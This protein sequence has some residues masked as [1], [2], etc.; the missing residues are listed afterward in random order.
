MKKIS[1]LS[2]IILI[3]QMSFGQTTINDNANISGNWTV[4]NSPYIIAGRAIVPNGQTLTIEPG[5]EIRLKSSTS[6]MPS[7]FNY[8]SGNVGVIRVQGEITANGTVSNPIIFTRNNSG[9][10]GTILIDENSSS[11]S[12][13]SHCIIE[14]AKESRNVTGISSIISFNGGIT[15]YKSFISINQN[16]F[17]NN[18]INGLYIRE[19]TNSFEFSNNTIYNNETNGVVIEESTANGIN[20]IFYNNSNSASGQVSAIRSS[21]S[22]VYLVGNLIY[23]NDDFGIFTTNGGNHY[24]VN[25]TIFGNSQG[26]RVENGANT[27]IYNSI[28]Q[29]NT[30]NFATSSVGGAT[31]EMQYSLTNDATFPTNVTNISSNLLGSD[32]LFTNSGAN[33]FSLQTT[34]PAIDKGNPITTGLNI[35]A[36]DILGNTRVD[37]SIVDIGA[38]EFQHPVTNYTITTSSNPS[39]GGNTSGGGIFVSGS[40]VTV[41]ATPN[42]GYTFINWTENGTVVSTNANYSFIISSNRNLVANFETINFTITTSSNPTIGGNTSGGGII[43]SGS[44]VTVSATPNTGYTFINWTENGTVVS[45]NAN[46]SFIISSNRNLVAN[47]EFTLS[48][49]GNEMEDNKLVVFPNPTKGQIEIKTS[50]FSSVEIYDVFG[51]FILRSFENIIDLST[52]PSGIYFVNVNSI[53]GLVST[54]RIIKN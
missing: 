30:L 37:N 51:K 12:S 22:T 54:K 8:S 11:A 5:V 33:D 34:S 36:T 17:R 40:N 49:S 35:P 9:F 46:Y 52:L 32:A 24:I 47:F 1:I 19:V 7:W 25:N 50:E 31:V 53:K 28:I 29:D 23:N 20:N 6:T 16:E 38:I 45:T 27:F 14:Y 13:F 44:N 42:T 10:W 48:V 41:S 3:V 4:A 21:N 39:I 15:V 26:I 2:I 18:N 43:A